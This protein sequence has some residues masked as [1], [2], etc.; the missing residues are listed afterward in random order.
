VKLPAFFSPASLAVVVTGGMAAGK[1]TVANVFAKHD[2]PI[3]DADV[4]A[5]E[6]VA[7]G[8]AALAEIAADFGS[9][10]LT[11]GGELDRRRMRERI[12]GNEAARRRLEA[13]LH[14]RVRSEL[15]ARARACTAPYCLLAIPLFAESAQAYVWVDRVLVVDVPREVQL[16]RLMQRDGMTA[17]FAERA[18][19][20]QATRAQRL[21][22]ADDVIDNTATLDDLQRVVDR[23]NPLYLQLSV[24]KKSRDARDSLGTVRSRDG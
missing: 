24:G 23:L 21:A 22:L 10:M 11:S 14:P 20:S 6:L 13:I 12:F 8:Q 9:D 4:I 1:T 5:R 18:L 7:P 19:A 3:F 2:A 16:A 17:E 15:Q